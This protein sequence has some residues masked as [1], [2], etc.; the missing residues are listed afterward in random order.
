MHVELCWLFSTS[1]EA[2]KKKLKTLL[3]NIWNSLAA[4]SL[5][6]QE[7]YLM[8]KFN[9]TL[10][11]FQ[12]VAKISTGML[13]VLNLPSHLLSCFNDTFCFLRKPGKLACSFSI[14]TVL[15]ICLGPVQM[16]PPPGSLLIL[17][18]Q[19]PSP[20]TPLLD[21]SALGLYHFHNM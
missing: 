18:P 15:C 13:T 21:P 17:H 8:A 4:M 14:S 16:P 3:L 5:Y 9:S 20:S 7:W 11:R 12:L 6:T 19:L 1:T 2:W 10:S